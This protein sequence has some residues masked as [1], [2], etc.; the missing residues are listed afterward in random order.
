M[1]GEGSV[2][3]NMAVTFGMTGDQPSG[4]GGEWRPPGFFSGPLLANPQFRR[5]FL[6]R[7]RDILY[8][9]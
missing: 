6:K 8:R 7:T 1:G 2:F 3:F 5:V 4:D 9:V